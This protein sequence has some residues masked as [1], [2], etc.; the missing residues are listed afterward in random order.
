MKLSATNFLFSFSYDERRTMFWIFFETN[1]N[2]F[3][4]ERR[5][6]STIHH[7]SHHL[8]WT[9]VRLVRTHK[10]GSSIK[11]WVSLSYEY[12]AELRA[13]WSLKIVSPWG[14]LITIRYHLLHSICRSCEDLL[15]LNQKILRDPKDEIAALKIIIH[16]R[17][18]INRDLNKASDGS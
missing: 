9:I 15:Y 18:M 17:Q 1:N 6:D 5:F 11:Q 10:S 4:L 12:D 3:S 8:S 16:A 14:S 13:A 2:F 7:H